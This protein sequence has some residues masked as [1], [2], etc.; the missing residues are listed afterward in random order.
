[1]AIGA[2]ERGVNRTAALRET[3]SEMLQMDA[4]RKQYVAMLSGLDIHYD[5]GAGH[6]LLGRRMPDL[7]LITAK[8]KLRLSTLLHDGRAKLL[9]LEEPLGIDIAPWRRRVQLINARYDGAWELPR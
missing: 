5:F 7:D 9:N 1:M 6:P 2:L 8:G 4:A 3:M